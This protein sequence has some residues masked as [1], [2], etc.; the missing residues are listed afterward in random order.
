MTKTIGLI[1]ASL[2][3]NSYNRI[4]GSHG[5]FSP[6]RCYKK[7]KMNHRNKRIIMLGVRNIKRE[8]GYGI[9]PYYWRI[10]Y[11]SEYFWEVEKWRKLL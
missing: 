11:I 6:F 4:I 5:W 10:G 2:R 3:N 1:C 8:I 9:H 7:E